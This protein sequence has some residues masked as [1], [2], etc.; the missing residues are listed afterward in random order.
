MLRLYPFGWIGI[1]IFCEKPENPRKRVKDGV[2]W[3]EPPAAIFHPLAT[4]TPRGPERGALGGRPESRVCRRRKRIRRIRQPD[5]TEQ[6]SAPQ[7]ESEGFA[8]QTR[9]NRSRR[10]KANPQDPPAGLLQPL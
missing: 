8:G 5:E 10:R 6:V 1:P 4:P 2:P 7:S 9:P 3:P